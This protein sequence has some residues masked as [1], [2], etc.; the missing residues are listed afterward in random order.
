MFYHANEIYISPIDE[1]I[2]ETHVQKNF[3]YLVSFEL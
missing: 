1:K 3:Y 2:F